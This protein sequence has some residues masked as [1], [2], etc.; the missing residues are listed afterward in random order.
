MKQRV[1]TLALLLC[2]LLT[3]CG[4]E[5]GRE[6]R[7]LL[8]RAS[9]LSETETLL[10]VD[11]REVPGW[12]YLYWL[13][14]TCDHIC[15]QY[16][17]DG[18]EPDWG[19]ALSGGTLADYARDQALADTALYA[20]VENWAAEYG[21]AVTEQDQAALAAAWAEKVAERGGEEAYLDHLADLG[22][23]KERA[24]ELSEV[25]YLY[26]HLYQLSRAGDGPLAPTEAEL[27]ACA[28]MR[29]TMTVDRILVAA[30]VDRE[31]ARQRAA[32]VFS[33]LNGAA[34]QAAEFA[35]LAAAGDDTAG[36]RTFRPGDGTLDAALEEA[37][38]ALE[39]GQYS[40][41]LESREGF[42]ILRRL[43]ADREV[44]LADCFD[45]RL[46]AAAEAASVTLEK[47]YE[48]LDTAAFSA[49]LERERTVKKR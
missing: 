38:L 34:D 31:A 13:A 40:G 15:S 28:R 22:L 18:G 23:T 44:L 16:G 3:A 48:K 1:T 42:S 9:G 43:P 45:A 26:S 7:G 21:C 12:R 24:W 49:A 4:G 47:A 8:E 19:M 11:G 29:G 46:Q 33:R 39:E 35:A 37:A 30:G 27:E 6:D 10:T 14:C 2:L 5:D 17:E 41:I 20:T 36:P 32:A 25:G